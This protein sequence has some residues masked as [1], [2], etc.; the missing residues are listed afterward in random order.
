MSEIFFTSDWHFS[1]EKDFIYKA[2]GFKNIEEHN[3]A[4]LENINNTVSPQDTLYALGDLIMG[5]QEKSVEYLRQIR[6]QE[7]VVILGNHDTERKAALYSTLPNFCVLGYAQQLKIGKK[8][9]YLS[10][11]PTLTTNWGDDKNLWQR[12][13]NLCGHT[14]TTE[15]FD[16]ATGSIH[17]EVDAWDNSPVNYDTLIEYIRRE[18]YDK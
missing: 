10:H 17:V 13:L 1:H 6:C 3:E 4:I 18:K 2:R 8:F 15:K 9:L 5:D 12:T 11:Y 7:V 14:H 16:P